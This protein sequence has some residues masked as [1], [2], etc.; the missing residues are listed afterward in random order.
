LTFFCVCWQLLQNIAE[1]FIDSATDF[2]C[3]LAKHRDSSVLEAKDLR[4]CLGACIRT[5]PATAYNLLVF[6]ALVQKKTGTSGCL[7]SVPPARL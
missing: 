1:D 7:A 3:Q 2:A 5:T 4:M 6:L